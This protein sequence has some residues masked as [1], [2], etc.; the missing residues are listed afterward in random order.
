LWIAD[1]DKN[2]ILVYGPDGDLHFKF[3]ATGTAPGEFYR[4]TGLVY[5]GSLD[6]IFVTDKDN[7]RI[8]IFDAQGKL[9]SCF[10][11]KGSLPGQFNYPWGIAVSPNG[12]LIAV[13]DTRN[14]RIQLFDSSCRFLRQFRV[15]D[16]KNW[17]EFRSL[18]DYPRGLAFSLTGE[19]LFLI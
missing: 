1:R 5:D 19:F 11:S 7:H 6:R 15:S 17:R 10:G 16:K 18:F 8:Q 2:E 3:G 9:L 13:A 12:A 4:P 14:H